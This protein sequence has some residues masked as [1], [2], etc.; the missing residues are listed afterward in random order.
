MSDCWQPI[1]QRNQDTCGVWGT[2]APAFTVG[3][4]TLALHQTDGTQLAV[5]AQL[6]TDQEGVVD[7]ARDARDANQALLSGLGIRVP[8]LLEGALP[9]GD[10]LLDDVAAVQGMP[11]DGVRTVQLRAQAPTALVLLTVA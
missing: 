9:V 3:E 6:K 5:L 8:R 1:L 11:L 10:A 2:H 7:A 4:L